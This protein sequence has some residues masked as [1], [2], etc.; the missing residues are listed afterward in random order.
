MERFNFWMTSCVFTNC[1]DKEFSVELLDTWRDDYFSQP[2][3]RQAHLIMRHAPAIAREI[4]Q[5]RAYFNQR[6]SRY[7]LALRTFPLA[8]VLDLVPYL[9]ALRQVS[10]ALR[11]SINE[12][13]VLDAFGGTGFLSHAFRHSGIEFTVADCCPQ[14]LQL[15]EHAP[16]NVN[17]LQV[18]DYFNELAR[19]QPGSFDLVLCHGG[20]HHVVVDHD[21]ALDHAKS[22]QR[23][24]R[25]IQ[26]FA[27]LLRKNGSLVLGDVP[28]SPASTNFA[29]KDFPPLADGIVQELLGQ[30]QASRLAE[31]GVRPSAHSLAEE[32]SQIRSSL[33]VPTR[34]PVPRLFFDEFVTKETP[35]GHK[36]SFLSI[37]NLNSFAVESGLSLNW[38]LDYLGP[39]LFANELEAGWYFTEKFSFGESQPV[40]ADTPQNALVANRVRSQLGSRQITQAR[41]GVNWGVVYSFL[42]K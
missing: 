2:D 23:Q 6:A 19:Q 33:G 38:Q 13:R 27:D 11:K 17:W 20:L 15:G 24:H 7:A 14:M 36:A 4:E 3:E 28:F 34:N 31:L 41:F 39:W 5:T 26:N 1:E 16:D 12:L 10:I 37:Q 42:T 18:D 9:Y 30:V 8:R 40:G 21:G 35:L 22:R 32:S 29:G 25:V